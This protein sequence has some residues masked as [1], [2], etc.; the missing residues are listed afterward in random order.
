MK[1]LARLLLRV[2]TLAVMLLIVVLMLAPFLVTL[3]LSTKTRLE[4]IEVPPSLAINLETARANYDAV[5]NQR[6]FLRFTL[7][8]LIVTLASTLGALLLGVPA[9]YGF[10]RFHFRG[11]DLLA[12]W[13]LSNRFLPPVAIVI[14]MFL[15]MKHVGL[16]DRPL[17]MIL[18]YIA[19]GLPLVV[20]LMI[21]FFDEVPVE[22]D[23]AALID[24]CSHLEAV[25][26]ILLPIVRPGL[27]ATAIFNVI[28]TWN[29]FLLALFIV[30]SPTTETV[31]VAAAG[32]ISA[33]RPID[34]NIAATVGVVT[35]VPVLIFALLVQRHIARGLT[36]GAVKG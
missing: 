22:L 10:S 7:N 36:A 34:W 2:G 23:E 26:R 17:G 20:W 30:S 33:Q 14:P 29:E 25:W 11:R 3:L 27:A 13:V 35:M 28:F 24:G 12:S 18:P 6:G 31:P 21:G 15:I 8:S 19:L 32:L 16:L 1:P 4:V 9:A 5:I